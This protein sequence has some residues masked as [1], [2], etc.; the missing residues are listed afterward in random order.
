[1]ADFKTGDV[2]T[3][4]L[5]GDQFGVATLIH[6]ED[7]A[8]T[9]N[10]HLVIHDAVIEGSDGGTNEFGDQFDREHDPASIDTTATVIDHLGL[11]R[12]GLLASEPMLVGEREPVEEEMLGYRVWLAS[13]RRRA[14]EQGLFGRTASRATAAPEMNEDPEEDEEI[15]DEA[16]DEGAW[17]DQEDGSADTDSAEAAPEEDAVENDGSGNGDDEIG[18]GENGSEGTLAEVEV[19]PWH[20]RLFDR[21]IGAALFEM[22]ESFMVEPLL[23]T[24]L[25]AYIAGFYDGSRAEEIGALIDRLVDGDYG[26]GQELLEYGD[27]AVMPLRERLDQVSEPE[28]V[29]DILQILADTGSESAYE[30]LAA[31]FEEHG[32]PE[33]DPLAVPAVRALA[34]AVMLTGGTPT[35]LAPHL[36]RLA[37]IEHPELDD[38]IASAMSSVRAMAD[39]ADG[40]DASP[41]VGA[42]GRSSNP[43]G[44]LGV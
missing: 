18:D 1:M 8:L 20:Q 7:L 35:A 31:Y 44:T 29:A 15:E 40:S 6:I 43:F 23:S 36:E 5:R 3:F 33:N 39:N 14:E 16:G 32:D 22:H 4:R 19:R 30:A 34:Y 26:A 11:T 13:A 37:A 25:G 10:Y 27:A 42:G 28:T 21:P 17:E 41:E 9:D 2:I 38:D 24:R 12:D